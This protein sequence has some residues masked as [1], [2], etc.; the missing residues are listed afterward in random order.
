MRHKGE[1]DIIASLASMYKDMVPSGFTGIGDDC[2]V[3]PF[4]GEESLV[5]TTDMLT[6]DSHFLRN[7]ISPFQLGYKSLAVNLSDVCSMGASPVCTF[8]SV[9]LD[10]DAANG[11][12]D[13]FNEGYYKLS[14]R[15][16]VPLLGG[17]TTCSPRGITINVTAIGKVNNKHLK[18][19]SSALPGDKIVVCDTLGDSAAGLK[20]IRSGKENLSAPYRILTDKHLMPAPCIE[21]GIW[22]GTRT[23][24]HAMMDI[25]DGIAKDLRQILACSNTGAR[26]YTHHLP[27]SP[28]LQQVCQIENWN[29][30]ELA[31]CGGEDYSLLFTVAEAK[32]ETLQKTYYQKFQEPLSVIG[33]ITVPGKGIEWYDEQGKQNRD[34][35][36]FTHFSSL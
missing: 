5:I 14:S 26:I 7:K 2:A 18:L 11:W 20:I 24:V 9:A 13:D 3:L 1:P 4:S 8:L 17:D 12:I 22:L 27:L 21:K 10:R 29:P 25:S 35:M 32:Y 33:E 30:T 23:E 6:E 16:N 19:R 28:E 34:Y 31:L 36:G 15:Y